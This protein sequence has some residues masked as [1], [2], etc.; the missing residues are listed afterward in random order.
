MQ[1]YCREKSV[2]EKGQE[3]ENKT[4]YWETAEWNSEMLI[5]KEQ[6]T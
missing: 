2:I 5:C 1:K 4:R 6:L 3:W